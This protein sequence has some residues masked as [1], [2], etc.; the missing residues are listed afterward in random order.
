MDGR[1]TP[2]AERL[3]EWMVGK[4]SVI[5]TAQNELTQELE[6]AVCPQLSMIQGGKVK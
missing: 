3:L 6:K 2:G 4:D 5:F 1:V